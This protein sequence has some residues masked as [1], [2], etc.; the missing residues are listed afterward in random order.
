MIKGVVVHKVRDRRGSWSRRGD[1]YRDFSSE[2]L[3]PKVDVEAEDVP[4]K[5]DVDEV[6]VVGEVGVESG[7]R[8]ISTRCETS[9]F[10]V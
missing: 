7:S 8:G 6:D 9:D 1:R 5:E 3:G 2:D 4:H 10:E